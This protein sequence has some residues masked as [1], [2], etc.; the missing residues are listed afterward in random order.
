MK[1]ASAIRTFLVGTAM[2]DYQPKFI[3]EFEFKY[4]RELQLKANSII[5]PAMMPKKY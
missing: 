5:F 3:A 1:N 2:D 4:C